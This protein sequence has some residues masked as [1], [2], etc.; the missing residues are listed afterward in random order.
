[1]KL[2]GSGFRSGEHAYR[3]SS[4]GIHDFPRLRDHHDGTAFN[5]STGRASTGVEALDKMLGDGYWE[6]SSA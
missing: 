4:A 3:I 2:R 1:M 6:G 5:L